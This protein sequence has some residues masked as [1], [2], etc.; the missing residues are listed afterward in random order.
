MRLLCLSSTAFVHVLDAHAQEL[1]SQLSLYKSMELLAATQQQQVDVSADQPLPSP[2]AAA[3]ADAAAPSDAVAPVAAAS[4]LAR[5]AS[6]VRTPSVSSRGS[7]AT[8]GVAA[9][10]EPACG[11][12]GAAPEL[13]LA[14][15]GCVCALKN[16]H[17]RELHASSVCARSDVDKENMAP[18]S[19][20]GSLQPRRG[21]RRKI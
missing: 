13:G 5:A 7:A 19:V 4:G 14:E 9:A 18:M 12:A 16:A 15:Y 3:A 11:V 8:E 20:G 10:G 21:L 2:A 1:K 6:L 17:I